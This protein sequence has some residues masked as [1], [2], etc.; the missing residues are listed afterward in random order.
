MAEAQ[1]PVACTLTPEGLVQRVADFEALFAAALTEV[2]R[3]PL[4]LRLRFDADA[5]REAERN[6]A[7]TG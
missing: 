5:A 7:A 3:E 4:R 1:V 6:A 2:E